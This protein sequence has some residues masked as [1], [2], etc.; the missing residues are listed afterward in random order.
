MY[1]FNGIYDGVCAEGVNHG[2]VAIGY[3]FDEAEGME[4]AI[5][6]NSW[7][8]NWGE[9]GYVRVALVDDDELSQAGGKCMMLA[10]PNYPIVA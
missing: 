1:Y 2:M 9:A 8:P 10:Y 3:G 4:Y 7:G 5:V 6:R